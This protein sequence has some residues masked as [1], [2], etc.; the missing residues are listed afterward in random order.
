ML[1]GA[2]RCRVQICKSRGGRY[3]KIACADTEGGFSTV[4]DSREASFYEIDVSAPC[5]GAPAPG[6]GAGGKSGGGGGGGVIFIIIVLAGSSVYFAGGFIFNWKVKHLEG[7]ERIPHVDFWAGLPGLVKEGIRFL[8]S[9]VTRTDCE[10]VA[11]VH[12]PRAAKQRPGSAGWR[13]ARACAHSL[14]VTV[15]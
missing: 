5:A 12:P 3:I 13:D 8:K 2:I 10:D 1:I 7:R 4:G 14:C 11:R 9:K 6:G 15:P